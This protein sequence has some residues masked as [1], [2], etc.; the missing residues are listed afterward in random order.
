MIL[1][2]RALGVP[3]RE[4][5]RL[6]LL[7]KLEQRGLGTGRDDRARPPRSPAAWPSRAG[8]PPRP[9]RGRPRRRASG[10]R[11]ARRCARPVR[12]APAAGSPAR[13]RRAG[14][15]PAGPS[16]DGRPGGSPRR[17]SPGRSG[18]RSASA[19]CS[20]IGSYSRMKS[21]RSPSS[22][23]C[24]TPVDELVKPHSGTL[25][26]TATR[27]VTHDQASAM[28]EMPCS[29][30]PMIGLTLEPLR[31]CAVDRVGAVARHAEQVLDAALFERGHDCA[32]SRGPVRA[33]TVTI[34]LR[35]QTGT[36]VSPILPD[37]GN[38]SA[39]GC[40]VLGCRSRVEYLRRGAV[41]SRR[42]GTLTRPSLYGLAGVRLGAASA[43]RSSPSR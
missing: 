3:I 39:T 33:A 8:W 24:Q 20:C 28:N 29:L 35:A 13:R 2:E 27:L 25:V 10:G 15:S 32:G 31:E 11:A 23:A 12:P 43:S 34:D 22:V 5:R 9:A 36:G 21:I 4:D 16:A 19:T 14:R 40:R 38:W 18:A 1:W 30:R 6:E 37:A 42:K 7:G 41:R 17:C 26:A